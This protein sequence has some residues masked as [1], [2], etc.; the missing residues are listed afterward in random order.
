M[1]ARKGLQN[2]YVAFMQS[3]DPPKAGD[4]ESLFTLCSQDKFQHRVL[5]INLLT[6]QLF[7]F[8]QPVNLSTLLKPNE[9]QRQNIH[10]WSPRN[11]GIGY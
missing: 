1:I 3:K 11:G 10:S 7:N 2:K 4:K 9:P 8:T 5:L 6:C